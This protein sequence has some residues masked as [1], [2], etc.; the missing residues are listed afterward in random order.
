MLR[1]YKNSTNKVKGPIQ[2]FWTGPF[3]LP[4]S[5]FESATQKR[6]GLNYASA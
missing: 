6:R 2:I 1:P 5:N 4:L 3:L